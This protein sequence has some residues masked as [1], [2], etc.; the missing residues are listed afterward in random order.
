[1]ITVSEQMLRVRGDSTRGEGSSMAHTHSRPFWN[2][3]EKFRDKTH[4]RYVSP[5]AHCIRTA[6]KNPAG[7]N[8]KYW[9]RNLSLLAVGL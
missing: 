3:G 1:M 5:I 4:H 9:K 6:R 7:P 8:V 2:I